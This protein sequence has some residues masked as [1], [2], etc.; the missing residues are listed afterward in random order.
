MAKGY[1]DFTYGMS[2]AEQRVSW[3][4]AQVRNVI[5]EAVAMAQHKFL[6]AF[7][8]ASID[9]NSQGTLVS[10]SGRGRLRYVL[11][12]FEG[13]SYNHW[14][15]EVIINIDGSDV[16]DRFVVEF[17]YPL[18]YYMHA[19]GSAGAW[20]FPPWINERVG[21]LSL[22]INSDGYWTKGALHYLVDSDYESSFRISWWNKTDESVTVYYW[23]QYGGYI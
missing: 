15:D 17:D 5:N 9:A 11:L 16:L 3:L 20:N 14:S 23:V 2:I 18:G 19:K 12:F 13:N 8:G 6:F 21:L 10:V 7:G 4:L 1:A 22:Y